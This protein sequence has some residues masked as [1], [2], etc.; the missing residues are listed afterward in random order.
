MVE[1]S[2]VR[3]KIQHEHSLLVN[4]SLFLLRGCRFETSFSMW[5]NILKKYDIEEHVTW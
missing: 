1:F 4:V 5:C 2:I 3:K